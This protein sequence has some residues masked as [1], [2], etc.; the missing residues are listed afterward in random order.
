M[1]K[2]PCSQLRAFRLRER[3]DATS[4]RTMKKTLPCWG[5]AV[6]KAGAHVR[7]TAADKTATQACVASAFSYGSDSLNK[8]LRIA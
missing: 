8:R 5:K 7:N 6:A 3:A 2:T 4:D 1:P